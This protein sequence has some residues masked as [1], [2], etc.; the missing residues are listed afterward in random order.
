MT[1]GRFCGPGQCNFLFATLGIPLVSS[2]SLL[3]YSS[4]CCFNSSD[5]TFF[6]NK[7][8]F[9]HWSHVFILTVELIQIVLLGF[10]LVWDKIMT[11]GFNNRHTLRTNLHL[12]LLAYTWFWT[13]L[14]I[15][16]YAHFFP[17]ILLKFSNWFYFV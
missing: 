16:I 8:I 7:L 3:P 17:I 5:S 6:S 9:F 13:V 15:D 14:Y 10:I 2:W 4:W 12:I 11:P 1:V